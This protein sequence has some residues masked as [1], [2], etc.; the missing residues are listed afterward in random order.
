MRNYH[1]LKGEKFGKLT[2][3]KK[4]EKKED[5]YFVWLCQ[6]D[7]GRTIE[8]NTKRLKR[9]TITNCGC[10]PHITKRKGHIAENI[11]GQRFGRLIALKRIKNKRGRTTWECQCD[12]GNMHIATT[13]DLKDAYGIIKAAERLGFS[14]KGVKGNR[15]APGKEHQ[16]CLQAE[17]SLHKTILCRRPA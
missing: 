11:T 1:D 13:K 7:C 9:G 12:C 8:V 3:L 14:A 10:I 17:R 6:C 16:L 4:L 5:G 2:V 15:D